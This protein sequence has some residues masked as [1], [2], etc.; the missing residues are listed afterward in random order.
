MRRCIV[1]L[2]AIPLAG[3]FSAQK[4]ALAQC[5]IDAAKVYPSF[6]YA[7]MGQPLEQIQLCMKAAGYEWVGFEG[8]TRCDRSLIMQG[9]P[10]NHDEGSYCFAP[11]D[12]FQKWIYGLEKPSEK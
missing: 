11:A 4:R 10:E 6:L 5:E 9:K 8:D 2:L 3:S 7:P 12:S 1:L